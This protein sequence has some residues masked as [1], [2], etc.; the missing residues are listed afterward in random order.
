MTDAGA[1]P[2]GNRPPTVVIGPRTRLG[3]ELSARALER[4]E[5][6]LAIARHRREADDLRATWSDAGVEV[7]PAQQAD[8]V[9]AA[10]VF[11]C[12][13]GPV[14]SRDRVDPA[15][16]T[17]ELAV[18]ARWGAAGGARGGLGAAG[19]A[20]APRLDRRHYA[21]WKN[22]V[23]S[24]VREIAVERGAA[25]AVLYPGRLVGRGSQ[26]KWRDFLHTPYPK[27]AHVVETSSNPDPTD[28]TVG[29]DA[30]FWLLARG[31]ALASGILARSGRQ[32]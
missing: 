15:S 14:Q 22:L 28:R 19:V 16:G 5:R 17:P 20:W 11:V 21:G 3:R 12:A 7:V 2:I 4:G 9:P 31:A 26:K 13:L 18:L 6:V 30:R 1:S 10:Q 23:E 29:L 24:R 25:V 32:G 27:L 8:G